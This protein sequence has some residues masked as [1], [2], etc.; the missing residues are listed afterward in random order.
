MNVDRRT[1]LVVGLAGASA[2]LF[3]APQAVLAADTKEIA[4]G[5]TLKVLKKMPSD[6]PGFAN[7]QWREIT[8]QP[9]AKL[10]PI[11]MKNAMIC[12]ISGGPLE[13]TIEGMETKTL[14]PGDTYLCHVGMVETDT[15]NGTTPTTMRV[16]DLLTA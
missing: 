1:A 7:I 2:L 14:Q 3:S 6:I 11:A 4:P 16:I 10:G 15:N 9:G 13:Q 8:W 12:E 5:V